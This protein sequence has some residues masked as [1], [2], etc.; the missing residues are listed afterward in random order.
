MNDKCETKNISFIKKI[1]SIKLKL[2]TVI[3]EDITQNIVFYL[4]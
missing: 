2:K 3:N 1:V 4:L